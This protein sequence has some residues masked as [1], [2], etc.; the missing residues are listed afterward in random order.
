MITP[1][2]LL[3]TLLIT[4]ASVT[5][6]DEKAAGNGFVSLFDGNTMTGWRNP[7][8]WGKIEVVNG[9]IHLTG[10]RKFFVVTERTY[11][12]FVFEGEIL[13]PEGKANSGFMFRAHA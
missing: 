6:A 1:R 7:Y 10:E 4:F 13:L 12:D 3:S 9:E 2:A 8:G 5:L 11:G